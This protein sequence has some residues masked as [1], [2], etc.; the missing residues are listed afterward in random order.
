[1]QRA[2]DSKYHEALAIAREDPDK[3]IASDCPL[4]V[5]IANTLLDFPVVQNALARAFEIYRSN[6]NRRL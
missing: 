3:G 2:P 1:M 4:V 6:R 5:L